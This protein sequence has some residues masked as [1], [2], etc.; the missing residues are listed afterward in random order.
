MTVT[1]GTGRPKSGE[2]GKKKD[3]AVSTVNSCLHP[4]GLFW[5]HW[6]NGAE[7]RKFGEGATPA[8]EIGTEVHEMVEAFLH[9]DPL[10]DA[11]TL[12]AMRA[13]EAFEDW[14]EANTFEII[15]TEIPLVSER[16]RFGGT[17]DTI[18]RDR[19]GR[20]CLGDWKTSNG[21]YGEYLRQV[22]AYGVLWEENNPDQPLDGGYHVVRFSKEHG[23]MEHRHF[24]ELDDARELFLLLRRAYDLNKTVERRA[25]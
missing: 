22:A 8:K 11:T 1:R 7:G 18:L 6:Q 25:R 5:W 19:R 3:P 24:N 16:Y 13:F 2:Y 12:E 21:I 23:D 9:G 20:I 14:W 10:P 17:V 15:A 4:R